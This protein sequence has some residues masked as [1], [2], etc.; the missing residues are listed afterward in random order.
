MNQSNSKN[1]SKLKLL[2]IVASLIIL[3]IVA[4]LYLKPG[5]FRQSIS[6]KVLEA[7][8]P[9]ELNQFPLDSTRRGQFTCVL[10]EVVYTNDEIFENVFVSAYGKCSYLDSNKKLNT[11]KIPLVILVEKSDWNNGLFTYVTNLLGEFNT[12]SSSFANDAINNLYKFSNY[13]V[14]TVTIDL[15][16]TLESEDDPL[17][18]QKKI[19]NSTYQ[20]DEIQ[21]FMTTGNESDLSKKSQFGYIFPVY[22]T[23]NNFN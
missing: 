14:L 10:S 20:I 23:K 21:K 13:E 12:Y 19:I 17:Y 1:K 3:S 11:A 2:F 15:L 7:K 5:S 16:E 8:Y 4:Y 18:I 6:M 22:V 9:D